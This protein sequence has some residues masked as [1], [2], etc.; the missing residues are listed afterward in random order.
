MKKFLSIIT[1]LLLLAL[2]VSCGGTEDGD[3]SG[4]G[5]GG[6]GDTGNTPT[7]GDTVENFVWDEDSELY[8]IR[9]SSSV[10]AKVVNNLINKIT[11]IRGVRPVLRTDSA[12]DF[13][14]ELVIGPSEKTVAKRAARELEL[15]IREDSDLRGYVIYT[16][17]QSVAVAFSDDIDG[18]AMNLAITDLIENVLTEKTYAPGAGVISSDYYYYSKYVAEKEAAELKTRWD[19]L[20]KLIAKDDGAEVAAAIVSSLKNLYSIYDD[21]MVDWLANLYDPG[22]GGF[23]YSNSARD[24]R[25]FLPDVE[26]TIEALT[27]LD[28]SGMTEKRGGNYA[29]VLPEKVKAKIAEFVQS[30]QDPND[31]YFYHPQWGKSITSSRQ[32]R[33]LSSATRILNALGYKPLYKLPTDT[34]SASLTASIRDTGAAYAV[35]RITLA[36][37]LDNAPERFRSE[38]NYRKY[39]AGLDLSKNSYSIGNELQSS[40]SQINAYGKLLGVDLMKITIDWL[41]E[42][43]NPDTGLWHTE[44]GYYATNSLHKIFSVYNSAG[45]AIPN[46]EKSIGSAIASITDDTPLSAG[47][48]IYNAWSVIPYAF[49][50]IRAYNKEATSVIDSAMRDLRANAAEMIDISREKILPFKKDD[51]SFSYG[52]K[53]SSPTSQGAPAAVP[54]SRE[55][56]VNGNGIACTALVI[57]IFDAL[58]LG[59]IVPIFTDSDLERF[60]SIINNALPVDKAPAQDSIKLTFDDDVIGAYPENFTVIDETVTGNGVIADPRP[61]AKGNVYRHSHTPQ[62]QDTLTLDNLMDYENMSVQVFEGEFCVE[63]TD[64]GYMMQIELADCFLF[65]YRVKNGKVSLVISSTTSAS[66]SLDIDLGPIA[67]VGEWF[68]LKIEYFVGDHN[69]VRTIIYLN[70]KP[71]AVTDNY[72]GKPRTGEAEPGNLYKSVTLHFM[73]SYSSTVLFDNLYAYSKNGLYTPIDL[74]DDALHNVDKDKVGK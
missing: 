32:G 8:L 22:I 69:T 66:T 49:K 56:D 11:E 44:I 35:S 64:G 7:P 17:G 38:E 27:F 70:D 60:I 47:V 1:L 34:S 39:L 18:Y 5:N 40:V 51:G 61:G 3:G 57:H 54:G 71:F 33:D 28:G 73:K 43:Q 48:D 24:N 36:A 65:T 45:R 23:Y 2:L 10:T 13:T 9:N 31:G 53:Y 15:L 21:N 6:T 26:S 72:S 19:Y 55:G 46:V 12:G 25:G 42:N 59:T 37:S 67:S 62:N 30:L 16:N 63:S 4:T 74:G 58:E 52:P 20:E 14:H 50:N 29:N 41:D 68:K